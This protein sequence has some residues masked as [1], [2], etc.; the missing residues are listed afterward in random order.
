MKKT[1]HALEHSSPEH[2]V[3]CT[4]LNQISGSVRLDNGGRDDGAPQR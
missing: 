4:I 3:P 1:G 2:H